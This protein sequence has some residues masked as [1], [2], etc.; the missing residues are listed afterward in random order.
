MQ[1]AFPPHRHPTPQA[2]PVLDRGFP[3]LDKH[4]SSRPAT[5]EHAALVSAGPLWSPGRCGGRSS[6]PCQRSCCMGHRGYDPRGRG[7][8]GSRRLAADARWPVDQFPNNRGRTSGLR[9]GE[10]L[11][12]D[13]VGLYAKVQCPLSRHLR[14]SN[15][16]SRC[17][18]PDLGRGWKLS[19]R[20]RAASRE[21][22][23]ER[24]HSK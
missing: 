20:P 2:R 19:T 14:H 23:I 4:L 17:L 22:Y 7:G 3:Y 24:R 15:A 10:N 18:T 5:A 1:E 6:L 8:A 21:F 16:Q 12:A 11:T 9:T 13:A